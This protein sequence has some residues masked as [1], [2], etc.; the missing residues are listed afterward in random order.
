MRFFKNRVSH[1][2]A[3]LA[4]L[5]GH[6]RGYQKYFLNIFLRTFRTAKPAWMCPVPEEG[7]L[8]VVG[9][10][11]PN[12]CFLATPSPCDMEILHAVISDEL[13]KD[14]SR[15]FIARRPLRQLNPRF[16]V[17]L[18]K[19]RCTFAPASKRWRACQR[20]QRTQSRVLSHF[21]AEFPS[22]HTCLAL[23]C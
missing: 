20:R 4:T 6:L 3:T 16:P 14:Q 18:S 1:G 22:C 10:E 12:V 13:L 8:K 17:L 11:L 15:T 21:L 19:F 5:V 9:S 7:F 2:A 23:G